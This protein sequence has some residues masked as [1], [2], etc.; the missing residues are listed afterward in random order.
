MDLARVDGE[1]PADPRASVSQSSARSYRARR[2]STYPSSARAWC[3]ASGRSCSAAIWS[4]STSEARPASSSPRTEWISAS[5]SSRRELTRTSDNLDIH[6]DIHG[7]ACPELEQDR[8]AADGAV[9]A[10]AAPDF[11]ENPPQGPDGIVGLGEEQLSEL[12]SGRRALVQQ[13]VGQQRP[14]LAAAE[15]VPVSRGAGR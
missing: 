1:S 2:K 3:D 12:A 8:V 9:V 13:Q 15:L 11:G 7:D 6:G 14:A 10:Q 4:P 5:A